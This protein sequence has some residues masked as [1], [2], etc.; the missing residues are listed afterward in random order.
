MKNLVLT[1]ENLIN[2]K[3]VGID[4]YLTEVSRIPMMTPD[5][6]LEV[7]RR[8][9][10]GDVEAQHQLVK[11]NLRFVI[12]VAKTYNKGGLYLADLINEGN[13]GLLEAA[14]LFRTDFGFKF[15]SFAVW[16]IRKNI[17]R[18]IGDKSKNIRL[19][20]NKSKL[21]R[22]FDKIESR[23][24]QE[25]ERAPSLEE[26]TEEYMK[27]DTISNKENI[28]RMSVTISEIERTGAGT[29][30][31]FSGEDDTLGLID[32]L[33]NGEQ[34]PDHNISRESS[35]K[36]IM[37][38]INNLPAMERDVIIKRFGLDGKRP[39]T[40]SEIGMTYDFTQESAR[41]WTKKA[42]RKLKSLIIR[43][44]PHIRELNFD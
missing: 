6:E 2:A 21:L 14:S 44:N 34:S 23:L 22:D 17:L 11:A 41:I 9:E 26:I 25:F 3:D 40:Y 8:A 7:A 16:H 29:A 42:L 15:I 18:F 33:D 39:M 32:V 28:D 43:K 20:I 13:I 36:Y 10:Q 1:G 38:V 19:P 30:S 35:K 12:S 5:K 24:S 27:D 37:E 31:L 4:K